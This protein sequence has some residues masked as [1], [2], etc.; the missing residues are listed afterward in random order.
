MKFLEYIHRYQRHFSVTKPA[1]NLFFH[2][3]IHFIQVSHGQIEGETGC[4]D[5]LVNHKL[6][7]VTLDFD[8]I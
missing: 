1:V 7:Y 6:I 2:H 8:L 5:L 4:L 3:I